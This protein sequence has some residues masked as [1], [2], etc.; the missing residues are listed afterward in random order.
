MSMG[1]FQNQKNM[2]AQRSQRKFFLANPFG[3]A[4]PTEIHNEA[5]RQREVVDVSHQAEQPVRN[6]EHRPSSLPHRLIVKN[7]AEA[8]EEAIASFAH[9][10]RPLR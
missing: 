5:V 9:P 8:R 1:A 6:D 2:V 7:R 10:W 4:V 3:A